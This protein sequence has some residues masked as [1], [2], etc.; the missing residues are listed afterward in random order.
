M[1]ALLLFIISIFFTSHL[2]CQDIIVK[3]DGEEIQCTVKEV[4]ISEVKYTPVGAESPVFVINKA[5]IFMIK[6][7]WGEK[8]VFS[9]DD[10]VFKTG[11]ITP[12]HGYINMLYFSFFT[13]PGYG[14]IVG[15]SDASGVQVNDY[16]A[17]MFGVGMDFYGGE[18]LIPIFVSPRVNFITGQFTPDFSCDIG[19]SLSVYDTE[20]SSGLM[21]NPKIGFKAYLSPNIAYAVAIGFKRQFIDNGGN[22]FISLQT[23]F[24]F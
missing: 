19:Y 21:L 8:Q 11:K 5:D 9:T 6:Y 20:Y 4:G 16:F 10:E 18:I 17:I 15:F 12:S 7:S 3:K 22:N 23:G 2:F 14:Y 1:K 13:A 24:Q